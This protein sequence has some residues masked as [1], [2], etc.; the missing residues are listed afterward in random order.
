M[1][2]RQFFLLF[3]LHVLVDAGSY[4][5]PC[6]FTNWSQYRPG[7]GKFVPEDYVPGLC[8]HI[9]FA[10][11]W[12]DEKFEAKA[13]DP[14]DLPNDWSGPGMYKRVNALKKIDP[15]LKTLLSFGGW[16][17]GTRL[18][19]SMAASHSARRTFINSAID[20]AR[21]YDFDGVDIDWEYPSGP[22]DKENYSNF[23]REFRD[24]VEYEANRSLR[25]RLLITAAVAA[26][27]KNIE[28]GY[29]INTLAHLLDFVLLMSYDFHGAWEGVTGLNAPLYSQPGEKEPLW[30][31]AGS[32]SY[33]ASHGMPRQKI[34]L[35]IPTYG[36]GWT[37]SNPS[38]Q[39]GIGAP[40]STARS[41]KY[42]SEAGTAAYYEFC[43]M[44]ADGGRRYFDHQAGDVDSI[45]RKL[46]FVK[47]QGFGGAFV[48]TLDMD[49]FNGRCSNGN[50]IRYPL[51]GTIA[52]ELAGIT[53]PNALPT[54]GFTTYPTTS[55]PPIMGGYGS[56]SRPNEF[57]S[58]CMGQGDGFKELFGSCADFVLC[59]SGKGIKMSCP[60]SLEFSKMLGY[61]TY[62]SVSGCSTKRPYSYTNWPISATT[63][64]IAP[65][66]GPKQEFTCGKEH[67]GF[68]PDPNSCE[69]FYRCVG[70][71]AYHFDCPV[72]MENLYD[73]HDPEKRKLIQQQLVL[74]L[75]AHR[76]QQRERN[77]GSGPNACN[78]AHCSTMKSV[79]DYMIG[80]NNGRQCSYPHCASSRQIITHW[81][82]CTKDDCPVCKPLKTYSRSGS[83]TSQPTSTSVDVQQ[84]AN[85]NDLFNDF[86][87]LSLTSAEKG[88]HSSIT[89]ELRA[90]LV[91]KVFKA[92][93]SPT[94][95]AA[96]RDQGTK[97]L[98]DYSYKI[99]KELFE[100]SNDKEEY[101][102]LL[103]EKIYKIRNEIN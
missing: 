29:D 53:I 46:D 103:A 34:V 54:S 42:V 37:L 93:S 39:F 30:N 64:T 75:H 56:S 10:F 59:L 19:K 61:C 91:K 3:L 101:Y 13:Y 79:L 67:D 27:V 96:V 23:L 68:F 62:A 22:E 74:L 6:Y 2:V 33:W 63:T 26:G 85:E 36:R 90:Y 49:D 31:V 28:N 70:G 82:N 77:E 40:G 16:S 81:K 78:L 102:R 21:K 1:F 69:H 47:Q 52:K 66:A 7:R 5:R 32:A 41:T 76:C 48:W 9:L 100:Y 43:E 71:T 97:D 84:L 55:M 57:D 80:C 72:D 83:T 95:P 94:N 44:L 8:T 51:I 18:F 60:L 98:V 38:T 89:D 15:Q 12:M 20:F 86:T 58:A 50:G 88:W 99:E 65:Y 14:A 17:F 35:G 87:K 24:A 11:G 4:L 92:I 73:L 45:K 25:E